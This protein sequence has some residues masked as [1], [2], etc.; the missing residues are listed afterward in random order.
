MSRLLE[1]GAYNM[2][3]FLQFSEALH[4]M[5]VYIQFVLKWLV[6]WDSEKVQKFYI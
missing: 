5:F 1:N 4:A 2:S 3:E 6:A